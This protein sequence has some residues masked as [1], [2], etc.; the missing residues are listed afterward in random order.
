MTIKAL[1]VSSL[2]IAGFLTATAQIETSE[3][4]FYIKADAGYGFLTPGSYTLISQTFDG[5]VSNALVSKKGMGNGARF[6]GGLGVIVSDVINIG[7]DVEYLSGSKIT[8]N[9]SISNPS[10]LDYFETVSLSYH[11]LSVTPHV[12]FKA[13]SK[14]DYLIYNKLGLLLNLPMDIK[15]Y[16]YDSSFSNV[17]AGEDYVE[18]R[19]GT[20]KIG[21]TAGLDVAIGVQVRLTDKLRGYAEIFG[22]YLVLS[23]KTSHEVDNYSNNGTPGTQ[24]TNLTYI[25]NGQLTSS[26][27]G[28]T[29][30]ATAT[31]KGN[32]YNMNS[33][34][35]KIGVSYR[36]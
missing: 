9:G 6:G 11:A 13:V 4:K 34:G 31:K 1:F 10:G 21:L 12:I 16:K 24:I 23:P 29:L 25:K 3:S 20:Y 27:D 32:E 18:T 28:N 8:V 7:A 19:N 30:T 14:P 2:F 33:A 36:F 5:T 26:M 22:N 17:T 35:L 15:T